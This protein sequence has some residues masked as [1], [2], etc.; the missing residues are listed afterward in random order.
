M[1][2]ALNKVW[3]GHKLKGRQTTKSN[4][5]HYQPTWRKISPGVTVSSRDNTSLACPAENDGIAFRK[6]VKNQRQETVTPGR[7]ETRRRKDKMAEG[8][9][10]ARHSHVMAATHVTLAK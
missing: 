5:Y 8:S 4:P 6:G 2:A 3:R 10:S 1:P 7:R 9:I